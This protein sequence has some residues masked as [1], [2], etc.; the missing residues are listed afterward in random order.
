MGKGFALKLALN[1]IK[2]N[3]KFYLPYILA[4]AGI[5]MMF[6]LMTFLA[7]NPGLA[8]FEGANYICLIMGLGCVVIAVF[9]VVFLFYINS[10][11]MKQRSKE[12]G[13]YNILGMEK[14][15]IGRILFNENIVTTIVSLVTGICSGM[16]FSKLIFL[17]VCK[18]I[19]AVTPIKYKT[20]L[21]GIIITVILFGITFFL[22]LIKNQVHIH[23][24][25]P[26]ELMRGQNAGEKEPKTKW[27]L[28]ILGIVCMFSGYVISLSIT[29]PLSAIL[30]FFVAVILVIV[31]TY[32][33][34][35]T[36]SIM[37]LKLMKSNKQ[38]YYRMPYFTTIS[39]MLY[40]MKQNAVG[41]ANICILSTM[42]LV[43]VSTT[44]CLR[45]GIGKMVND[46]IPED[47]RIDV[48]YDKIDSV[49]DKEWLDTDKNTI[50]GYCDKNSIKIS[51]FKN[52]S[53]LSLYTLKN[54]SSYNLI[55]ENDGTQNVDIFMVITSD[56]Y[57]RITGKD[58]DISGKEVITDANT[59][60]RFDISGIEFVNK[61]TVNKFIPSGSA[62]IYHY[63]TMV[64]SDINIIN[65]LLTPNS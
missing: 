43:T 55:N 18:A 17:I 42:V 46:V 57:K 40:R 61:K 24:L 1:N 33:L 4:S 47:V 54:E 53:T 39:G 64:V 62:G 58:A 25:K 20:S 21:I 27:I 29:D 2:Q 37:I 38:L 7:T 5:I 35:T 19:G 11:L 3:R 31:G 30:L 52:Y 59:P 45:V 63:T 12:I 8:K 32:F 48:R 34:F 56:E 22:V 23:L 13:L 41:M 51:N 36:V 65:E 10:F 16:V 9:A 15:H 50:F 49:F 60:E 26:I 44:V 28:S 14:R 6:Y